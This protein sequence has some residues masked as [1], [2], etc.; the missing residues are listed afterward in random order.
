MTECLRS[1][2]NT[3]VGLIR[4]NNE[5]CYLID[6][7]LGLW[8]IADGM[9]G[10]EAG[11]VASRLTKQSIQLSVKNGLTLSEAIHKAHQDV[12]K[13][14]SEEGGSKNMGTTVIALQHHQDRFEIA[15][16]GDSRAY[17]WDPIKAELRQIS[18]DHSYVQALFDAGSISAE[19][20][21][22]H[23]QKHVI[24]QSL[25]VAELDDV[26]VDSAIFD[27]HPKERILLCSDGLSDLVNLK[28]L[29]DAMRKSQNKPADQ[30]VEK[31]IQMALDAG[32]A[33]NVSVCIIDAPL[34]IKSKKPSLLKRVFLPFF[35]K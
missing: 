25:G 3:H 16:V 21:E 26:R 5:D 31:F 2:G 8:L 10:H 24:T 19:E 15:W 32:G 14:G 34:K 6:E 23:P 27:W 20:M 17:A 35:A 28:A 9:G 13:A 22:N 33:D 30:L 29:S 7:S 18:K 4:T 12:K 1:A 11:E